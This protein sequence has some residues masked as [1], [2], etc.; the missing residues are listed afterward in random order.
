MPQAA[1]AFRELTRIC[2]ILQGIVNQYFTQIDYSLQQ[3]CM[4]CKIQE[5]VREGFFCGKAG[6]PEY[7]KKTVKN[8]VSFC[9]GMP[10]F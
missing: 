5:K 10:Y 3:I 8:P 1:G 7:S 4:T 6:Y 9:D 2:C